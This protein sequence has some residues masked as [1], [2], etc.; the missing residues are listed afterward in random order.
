MLQLEKKV[1][2]ST[3]DCNSKVDRLVKDFK[4]RF[5]DFTRYTTALSHLST[6][7]DFLKSANE[8]KTQSKLEA[9]AR[10]D[11]QLQNLKK[12]IET[13]GVGVV[14]LTSEVAKMKS[15]TS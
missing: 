3:T 10:R 15:V 7:V 5:G 13:V 9:K 6:S 8:K 2:E 11:E 4:L 12:T 14:D 1:E